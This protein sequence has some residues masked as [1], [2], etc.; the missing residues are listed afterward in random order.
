MI[1][2]KNYLADRIL[3]FNNRA[4]HQILK[5]HTPQYKLS[6]TPLKVRIHISQSNR[7]K[8]PAS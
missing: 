6:F 7:A 8:L 4:K 2:N 1:K 3:F 5:L